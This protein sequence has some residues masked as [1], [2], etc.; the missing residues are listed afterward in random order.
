MCMVLSSIL[1][2]ASPDI[3]P[4][5]GASTF[6]NFCSFGFSTIHSLGKSGRDLFNKLKQQCHEIIDS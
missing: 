5:H 3:S 1:T 6:I 4:I 2:V